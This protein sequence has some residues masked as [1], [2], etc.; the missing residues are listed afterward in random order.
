MKKNIPSS[1]SCNISHE[2]GVV[3]ALREG[4]GRQLPA[5]L[6]DLVP[7]QLAPV[8]VDVDILGAQPALALPQPAARPEDHHQRR[9]QVDLEEALGRVEA[10]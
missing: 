3:H 7:R 4:H 10:A 9:G 6:V 8:G 1:T 5:V 2:D